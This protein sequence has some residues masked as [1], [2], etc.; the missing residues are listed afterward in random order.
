[1]N[2][3]ELDLSVFENNFGSHRRGK[4]RIRVINNIKA[5]NHPNFETKL[6]SYNQEKLLEYVA[7]IIRK[8]KRQEF[9]VCTFEKNLSSA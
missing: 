5:N 2:L 4:Q 1:M 6:C 8:I 9:C 7:W 3:E